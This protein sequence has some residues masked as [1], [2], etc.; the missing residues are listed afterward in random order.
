MK[1]VTA[2]SVRNGVDGGTDRG[3]R[4]ASPRAS[5]LLV[6]DQPARLLTYEAVLSGLE[7]QCVRALSGNEALQ[8]LL[9]QEFAAILLDVQMPEIDGFE[10]AKMIREHP[11]LERTPIIFVTGVHMSEFDRLR[12][13][14]VGAIDYISVPVVPE[15]LRSKVAVLIEL[16]LKRRELESLNRELKD[17]H[18]RV[19]LEHRRVLSEKDSQ[20]AAERLRTAAVVRANDRYNQALIENAPVAIAHC[21]LNGTFQRVNKAFCDLLCYTPDELCTLTWQDVTHPEDVAINASLS[22]QLINGD[23]PHYTVQKRYIRKDGSIVWVNMFGNILRDE[24]GHPVQG[25]V[26]A[27]DI[28]DQIRSMRALRDSEE[29]LVLA[30]KG[31]R[32]GIFDWN[33]VTGSVTWD[34]RLHELWGTR[35]EEGINHAAFIDG[36]HPEDRE[37]ALRSMDRAMD[38]SRDGHYACVYRVI[39]RRDRSVRWIEASGK[40]SFESGRAVRFNG[41]VQDVTDRKDAE[42]R[43]QLIS[44]QLPLLISYVGADGRYRFCNARYC[45]WFGGNKE[46]FVGQHASRVLGEE[47][48]RERKHLIERAMGGELVAFEA[49][50]PHR[51]LGI[52]HCHVVYLPH[53]QSNGEVDGVYVMAHDITERKHSEERVRES[54][55]RFRNMA[56]SSPVMIWMTEPDG[57]CSYLNRRWYEFTGQSAQQ[58]GTL[59]WLEAVH[60]EDRT[61][62]YEE[63][64]RNNAAHLA[65]RLEYRLRNASGRYHWV[66]DT[67]APRFSE[68]SR[69]AGYIGSV[70][71]IS[72][73]KFMEDALRESEARFRELADAMPQI[74]FT[75]RPDGVTDYFNRKWYE[76]TGLP[77]GSTDDAVW[78]SRLHPDDR[79]STLRRWY[80]SARTGEPY[81]IEY[82]FNFPEHGGYRWHL[83]RALPVRNSAGQITRWY[84]TCTDVHDLRTAQERLREA[85]RRKDEFL[86]TL[87]HELR[88][89]LAPIRSAIELLQL[90]TPNEPRLAHASM[91]IDRQTQVMVRLVDDLLDLS[92]ITRGR[93]TLQRAPLDLKDVLMHAV[94]GS[95][96]LIEAQ[97]HE[98]FVS[99]PREPIFVDG[100]STRLTQIFSNLL[101]NAAKYT[102]PSGRIEVTMTRNADDALISVRD[103]GIGIAAHMLE[104]IFEM[105]TQVESGL[106]RGQ[107]GL[108]VGLTLARQLAQLHGGRIEARSAGIGAGSEFQVTLPI[109]DSTRDAQPPQLTTASTGTKRRILIADDNVDAANMLSYLLE[110]SGYDVRTVA[111]GPDALTAFKEY[112]PDIAILDIGMPGMTGYEVATAIRALPSAEHVLLIAVSG[113]GQESDRRNAFAAGFDHHLTKPVAFETLQTS[114]EIASAP[115]TRM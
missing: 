112:Q 56:D 80:E 8:H 102:P 4:S 86:A 19:E 44:D 95:R 23:L 16:H 72:E 17:M 73:R 18:A 31:A 83:A 68:Q 110:S 71:D 111:D 57:T 12:G 51:A 104:P 69:F 35:P 67:A 42:E 5:V 98:L 30:K 20:L 39:N 41:I 27:V 90:Q 60:E 2:G 32:L 94:D 103:N 89:P 24:G 55:K 97:R 47:A 6:D 70:I 10:L 63:F 61:R 62:V 49:P 52:R 26:I 88:N 107:G 115:K 58:A 87:A 78:S 38:P 114:L 81:Q 46:T 74:V 28:T 84:G 79:D 9:Q 40:V 34:E 36:I 11:R 93:I 15:I 66:M 105:F 50:V 33:L 106:D 77:S 75:A 3:Q 25:V 53:R 21:A 7:L 113:W 99:V 43:L 14:E 48:Y 82:R 13:Y 108:G 37:H 65:F 91:T 59:D 29:R 22:L 92:R 96:T 54:E 109:I 45:E 85:D 100:D 76:M 64:M 1:T 101:S